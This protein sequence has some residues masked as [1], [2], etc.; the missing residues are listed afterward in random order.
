VALQVIDSDEPVDYQEAWDHQRAWH[1]Q[2]VEGGSLP[3]AV[4]EA[5]I[6]RWI[7]AQE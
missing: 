1:A 5:R 6:D 4:L 2:V 7:A 3:L